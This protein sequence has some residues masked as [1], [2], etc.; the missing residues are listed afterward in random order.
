VYWL[1]DE[2]C[3]DPQTDGYI[4]ITINFKRRMNAHRCSGKFPN[5]QIMVLYEGSRDEA[6]QIE[7]GLRSRWNIGWNKAPGGA[8]CSSAAWNRGRP[9]SPEH[10]AKMIASKK[11]KKLGPCSQETKIKIGLANKGK[12][13][14]PYTMEEKMKQSETAKR[15][16]AK[17]RELYGWSHSPESVKKMIQ[18]RKN[19]PKVMWIT[20]DVKSKQIPISDPMPDGW[21]QGRPH[22]KSLASCLTL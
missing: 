1:Y 22:F 17:N 4:G 5:F 2:T 3:V 12:T 9:M 21:R 8:E 14:K 18:S 10:K 20:D 11:G 16:M 15:T 6:R 7:F 19:R 13:R